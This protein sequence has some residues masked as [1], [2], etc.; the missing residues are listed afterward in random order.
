MVAAITRR[1]KV[2]EAQVLPR[3]LTGEFAAARARAFDETEPFNGYKPN[4][5]PGLHEIRALG[6][7]LLK[8]AK[9]DQK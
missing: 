9:A 8:K 7:W 5:L 3:Y 1:A 6:S 4:E 2:H